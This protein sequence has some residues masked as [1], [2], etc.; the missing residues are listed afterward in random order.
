MINVVRQNQIPASLNTAEIQD[1]NQKAILY[2]KDPVCNSKPP[3]K[4]PYRNSDVLEAF[5]RDFYSKCYLTE[6]KYVN[7]WIM[8]IDHF[9]PQNERPDLVYDWNNL[10]PIS[11]YSNLIKPKKTPNGGLLD[12]SNTEDDVETEIIYSLPFNDNPQFEPLNPD[13]IKALNTCK[14]LNRIHNGHDES[15]Q[16]STAD[17]RHTIHK[18]REEI[19]KKIIEWRKHPEGSAEKHQAKGELKVFL[20]RESSFTML[21]RSVPAVR[22]LPLDFLD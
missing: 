15:T 9:L 4:A 21:I 8:P 2:L 5:D 6:Q 20:S 7:S 3:I 1:Y 22:Q 12:P 10:F 11:Y 13:N 19:L 18:R 17:L 16:K 14:L